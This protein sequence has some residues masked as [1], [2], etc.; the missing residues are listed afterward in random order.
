MAIRH[1][2]PAKLGIIWLIDLALLLILWL[3]AS[4]NEEDQALAILVWLIL[5]IPVFIITWKWASVREQLDVGAS[6]QDTQSNKAL[7]RFRHDVKGFSL[8]ILMLSAIVAY[9][10]VAGVIGGLILYYPSIAVRGFLDG[11]LPTILRQ[12]WPLLFYVLSSWHGLRSLEI[13]YIKW[14]D[15]YHS[16]L[17][18][19]NLCLSPSIPAEQ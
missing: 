2:H 11:Y 16:G 3:L 13:G 8:S 15:G 17:H 7:W 6:T 14:E 9:W 1:W 10:L 5:S 4:P 18:F 19:S 12:N